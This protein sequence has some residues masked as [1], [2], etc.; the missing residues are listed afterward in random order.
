MKAFSEFKALWDPGNRMNPGKVIEPIDRAGALVCNRSGQPPCDVAQATN[1]KEVARPGSS[2]PTRS[3]LA[4]AK[5]RC[6]AS[7]WAP[8]AKRMHGTMC[9]SYMAT[10]EEKH[11]TR[12]RA[13][14]LWEMLQGDVLPTAGAIKK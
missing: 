6:A 4:L 7:A 13:H 10:R 5:P 12:G 1:P 8:A 9:P 11:S 3:W 14:L 2:F